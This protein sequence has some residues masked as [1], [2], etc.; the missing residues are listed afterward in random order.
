MQIKNLI[1]EYIFI[2]NE[3]ILV[4]SNLIKFN[5]STWV[6]THR[7]RM[8]KKYGPI[9]LLENLDERDIS[10]KSFGNRK[11]RSKI[12]DKNE[13]SYLDTWTIPDDTIYSIVIPKDYYFLYMKITDRE[14]NEINSKLNLG[15][16]LKD[17]IFYYHL[18]SQEFNVNIE[19]LIQK[20]TKNYNKIIKNIDIVNGTKFFNRLKDGIGSEIK[21]PN[22]LLKL[23]EFG[24]R[25]FIK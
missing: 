17:E 10:I 13:I 7:D 3:E 20:N 6:S 8:G 21:N 5:L 16:T 18:F 22:Y 14:N 11:L 23:L 9:T 1:T 15:L 12:N 19:S 24:K 4:N 2:E 25:Y